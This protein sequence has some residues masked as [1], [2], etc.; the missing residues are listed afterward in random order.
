ME[1][2]GCFIS[3]VIYLNIT[4]YVI[5]LQSVLITNDNFKRTQYKLFHK[6]F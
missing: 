1:K 4:I 5:L 2:Y 3:H 6:L